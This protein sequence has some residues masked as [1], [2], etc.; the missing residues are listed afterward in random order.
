MDFTSELD[1][2]LFIARTSASA[3]YTLTIDSCQSALDNAK[4]IK[5]LCGP[6]LN[7]YGVSVSFTDRVL[8]GQTATVHWPSGDTT[9]LGDEPVKWSAQLPYG[10][11]QGSPLQRDFTKALARLKA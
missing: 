8:Q 11:W 2:L 5:A 1:C 4:A 6:I 10:N 9:Y 3:D 7:K